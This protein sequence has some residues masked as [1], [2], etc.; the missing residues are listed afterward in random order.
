M[1]T[2]F[3]F[4]YV[5]RCEQMHKL[6]VVILHAYKYKARSVVP[7]Y[8]SFFYPVRTQPHIVDQYSFADSFTLTLAFN[9]IFIQKVSSASPPIPLA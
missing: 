7:C 5:R 3:Y 8:T 6:L 9:N 4:K 2:R 1:L